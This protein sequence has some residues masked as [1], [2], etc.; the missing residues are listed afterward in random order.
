MLERGIY[1]FWENNS[2]LYASGSSKNK[3]TFLLTFSIYI[4]QRLLTFWNIYVLDTWTFF[5]TSKLKSCLK[6]IWSKSTNCCIPFTPKSV[7]LMVLW[8]VTLIFKLSKW[9]G[10]A[11]TTNTAFIKSAL[12]IVRETNNS[13]DVSI[14]SS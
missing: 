11:L 2:S 8:S 1:S 10:S 7:M 4:K 5:F 6:V 3:S 13:R 12:S 9:L 14:F